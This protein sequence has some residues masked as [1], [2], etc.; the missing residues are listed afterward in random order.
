MS[1]DDVM[2]VI[3]AVVDTWMDDRDPSE[4]R[5]AGEEELMVEGY[6]C[7][8]SAVP[9]AV[10]RPLRVIVDIELAPEHVM[11]AEIEIGGPGPT[12]H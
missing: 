12:L 10:D 6:R 3:R 11:R 7:V 5:L 9:G 1:G 8:V 4:L 2:G